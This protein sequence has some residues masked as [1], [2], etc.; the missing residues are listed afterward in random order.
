MEQDGDDVRLWIKAVPGAS[1]DQIAG[2]VG[3]RLKV[4]VSA[5][6]EGG[7]ANR[8]ICVLRARTL[9]VKKNQVSVESGATNSDKIVR[10]QGVSVDAALDL[11]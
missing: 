7:K 9:R 10:V 2:L 11:A 4:R 8:A 6:P 1:R 5:P 3:D